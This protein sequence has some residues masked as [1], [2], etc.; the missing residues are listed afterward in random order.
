MMD[1]ARKLTIAISYSVFFLLAN[2]HLADAVTF[3]DYE[4][5]VADNNKVTIEGL[6][7][8]DGKDLN[9]RIYKPPGNGPYPALVALHGA[10]GVFPYQLW[11]ART[12][13]KKGFVVLF[14]DHY[15]TRGYLCQHATGDDDVQRGNIMREWQAVDIRQRIV[16]AASAYRFL[17]KKPYVKKDQIGLIG[18]S[19]G[20]ATALFAQGYSERLSLP[21]GGFKASIAFYPNFKHWSDEPRWQNAGE[22]KQP[23]LILY[24]KNDDLE[25]EDSY[26]ELLSADHPASI[27]IVGLEGATKKFD[28]LG[29][30][31]TKNHPNVGDFTKGFH[32]P[33]FD[34]SLIE[35]HKFLAE[36]FSN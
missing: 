1:G 3:K 21:Y 25:S 5:A 16:D 15:C 14:V 9:A 29:E 6:S 28:E 19:W 33:A 17:T 24:G 18:W 2:L 4:I 35:V 34:R 13:S 20:G 31:R 12:I 26:N 8:G 36:N 22:I 27:K 32:Q 11:W 7:H 30:L 23:I 10:G